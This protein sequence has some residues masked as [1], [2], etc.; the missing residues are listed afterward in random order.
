MTGS[1][2]RAGAGSWRASGTRSASL[3]RERSPTVAEDLSAVAR[4]LYEAGTLKQ[5]KRTGWWMAGVRAPETG[6][7]QSW[8]PALL[9]TII[10]QLQGADPWPAPFLPGRHHSA[11]TGPRPR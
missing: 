3:R 4:F 2:R 6:A 1:C 8:R 5:T 9:A 11:E 7:Q 10:P